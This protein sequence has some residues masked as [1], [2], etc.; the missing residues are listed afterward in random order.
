MRLIRLKNRLISKVTTRFP[1]LAKR[2]INSYDPW[3]SEDIPWTPV[4]KSLAESKVAIVTTAGVHHKDQTPFDMRDPDGDPS[5]RVIDLQK[6]L[7][8]LM[9]THDYYNHSDA[10]HDI[11]IVFPIQRLQEFEKE[12]IIGRVANIHYGFMGHITGGHIL[13]LI[14]ITAPEVAVRLR[15][16]NVDAVLLTPG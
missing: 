13:T 9:I 3:E 5:Y 6:A 11:N 2:F 10:D 15:E 7:S 8:S 1:S 4:T 16:D 14:N 12:R